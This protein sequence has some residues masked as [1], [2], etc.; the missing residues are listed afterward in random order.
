MLLP[1]KKILI[2]KNRALG[3]SVLTLSSLQYLREILPSI[4]IE[5]AVPDWTLALYQNTKSAANQIWGFDCKKS[6]GRAKFFIHCWKEKYDLIIE[7]NQSGSSGKILKLLSFLTS[8]PYYF[9]NHHQK[10]GGFIIDQ[11]KPKANIQR[12]LDAIWSILTKKYN[13]KIA[14]P[15]FFNYPPVLKSERKNPEKNFAVFGVVATRSTKMW[16]LENYTNLGKLLIE[17]GIVNKIIIPLSSSSIDREIEKKIIDNLGPKVEIVKLSLQE[18]PECLSAAK[19]YVGN[20]TGLKHICA[21]LGVPTLTFFGPENP[22]EWH[23][24][25]PKIHPYFFISKLECRTKLS[26]FCP[27]E[28]CDSMICLNQFTPE[29][30]LEKLIQFKPRDQ[31][32]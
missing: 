23:P 10:N 27:L 9:H 25:D 8:V 29:M 19:F 32:L 24:Y 2:I 1:P 14:H 7:L 26:H 28:T 11:G 6:R 21:S 12:D 3:D 18:L 16:P 30:A 22:E 15:H 17:K 31:I 13:F 20:D 5:Y 4:Q